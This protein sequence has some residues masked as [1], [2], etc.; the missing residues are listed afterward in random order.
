MACIGVQ[1]V[2]SLLAGRLGVVRIALDRGWDLDHCPSVTAS[3]E[4]L[5]AQGAALSVP[6][7]DVLDGLLDEV[8]VP[9]RGIVVLGDHDDTDAVELADEL[10]DVLGWPVIAE[11]WAQAV[12][13]R[14]QAE[15]NPPDR[16][17]TYLHGAGR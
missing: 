15:I 11:P 4:L 5:A 8:H 9:A 3:Y 1:L 7:D 13:D 10:A 17:I 14:R 2:G 16:D 12:E 6:L